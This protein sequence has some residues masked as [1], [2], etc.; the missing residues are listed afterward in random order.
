MTEHLY[1]LTDQYRFL[2]LAIEGGEGEEDE[3]KA[4]LEEVKEHIE[5]KVENVGKFVLSLEAGITAIKSEEERLSSRRR[6]IESRI[7]W[8]KNYLLQ[9][10]T[11]A[12]LEKVKRDVLTVL[13]RL[14]PPSVNV[15]DPESIPQQFRRVIPET[16]QPDKKTIIDHFKDTGEIVPGIEVIT[17]KKSVQIR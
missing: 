11:L 15:L 3:L 8:L 16:W 4:K 10:M 17:D 9:E 1:Q 5:D 12:D 7:D 13:V 6:V 14:N 2:E